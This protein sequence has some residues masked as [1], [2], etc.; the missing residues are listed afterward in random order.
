MPRSLPTSRIVLALALAS[1]G[2]CY[3]GYDPLDPELLAEIIRS[4][5]DAAGLERSGQYRGTFE[6][7]SCGCEVED[8]TFDVTLCTGLTD[9]EEAGLSASFDLTVIQADGSVRLSEQNVQLLDGL[10]EPLLPTFYGSLDADGTVSAAGVL[11]TDALLVEG[12][13]L[14]RVDGAFDDDGGLTL[15]LQQR[16]RLRTDVTTPIDG[17]IELRDVDCREWLEL[18]LMWIALPPLP[19][20]PD[21]SGE[22]G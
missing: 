9:L 4:R 12:Q 8:T 1:L 19:L 7:L 14:G 21:P 3:Q 11:Q 10:G 16:Y 20:P 13:V 5:G 18:D 6:V 15:E 2:G 22:D 17:E